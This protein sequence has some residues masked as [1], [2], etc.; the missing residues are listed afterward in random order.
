MDPMSTDPIIEFPLVGIIVL[1][2]F[3]YASYLFLIWFNKG[4]MK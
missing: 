2:Y 1:A 4:G 3:L